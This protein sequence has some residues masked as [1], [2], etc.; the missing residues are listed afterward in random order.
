MSSTLQYRGYKGCVQ[1][2]AEDKMLHGRLLTAR[3]VISY[4]GMDL[5]EL[6]TSFRDAV[7]E[8]LAFCEEIG[9]APDKPSPSTVRFASF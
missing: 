2:S 1:Y 7:D 8:Y 3:D 9:K 4:G 6:A 5:A